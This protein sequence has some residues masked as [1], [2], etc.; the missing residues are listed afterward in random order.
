MPDIPLTIIDPIGQAEIDALLAQMP[1]PTPPV[2]LSGG[3]IQIQEKLKTT[4]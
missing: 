2:Y 1:K 4:S 3:N